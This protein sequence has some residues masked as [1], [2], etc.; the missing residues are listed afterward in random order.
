M[1][2]QARSGFPI[3]LFVLLK[4]DCE[5]RCGHLT[6]EQNMKKLALFSIFFASIA[7]ADT[8]VLQGGSSMTITPG[9]QP[10]VISCAGSATAA[11]V[12]QEFR[13]TLKWTSVFGDT[14]PNVIG[15]G[16]TP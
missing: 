9:T 3:G 6:G 7:S 12:T 16:A 15:I 13:C 14:R 2:T 1:K 10:T 4:P 8:V 11:V 5:L